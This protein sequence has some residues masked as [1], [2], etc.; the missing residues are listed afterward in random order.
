MKSD[1]DITDYFQ[2]HNPNINFGTE[3]KFHNS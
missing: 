3:M 2:F 1:I